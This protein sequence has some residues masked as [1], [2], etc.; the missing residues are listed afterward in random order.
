MMG[1]DLPPLL[2]GADGTQR[3]AKATQRLATAGERVRG[4]PST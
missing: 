4:L 2:A 1:S 3:L